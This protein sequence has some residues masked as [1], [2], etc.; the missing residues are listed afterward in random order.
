MPKVYVQKARKDYPQ[1]GIAKGDT[2]YWWK[3]RYSGKRLSKTCPKASQLTSNEALSRMYAMQENA[4]DEMASAASLDDLQSI[5]EG[6]ASELREI[7]GEE[8]D[9]VQNMPEQFQYGQ[10][11]EELQERADN[12]NSVADDLEGMDF[13]K[14]DEEE[15]D[16]AMERLSSEAIDFISNL[17]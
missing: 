14:D 12:C 6:Y 11:G 5:I 8:E 16:A 4:S 15:E 7:A 10:V 1:H 9:K 13:S 17:S 2:Y 3:F